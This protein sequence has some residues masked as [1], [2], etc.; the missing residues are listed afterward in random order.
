MLVVCFLAQDEHMLRPLAIS[1]LT[2][3]ILALPFATRA[4]ADNATTVKKPAKF[5]APFPQRED[6]FIPPPPKPDA[7]K[8]Q[9]LRAD[10][11]LKGFTNVDGLRVLMQIGGKTVPLAAGQQH[12]DV[13]VVAIE[14]PQVTLQRGRIRWTESL[15]PKFKPTTPSAAD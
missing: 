15:T 3:A 11:A 14:P 10:I 9:D 1:L 6:L 7:P 2:V 8:R 4:S 13:T 5:S 12:G